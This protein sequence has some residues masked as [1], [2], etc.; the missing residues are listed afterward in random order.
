MTS[1]RP[2]GRTHTH[3][4]HWRT[5]AGT[6]QHAIKQGKKPLKRGPDRT[7]G[8]GTAPQRGQSSAGSDLLRRG[9]R[10]CRCPGE[11]W[12]GRM[13]EEWRHPRPANADGQ[14]QHDG[15]HGQCQREPMQTAQWTVARHA[16]HGGRRQGGRGLSIGAGQAG[17]GSHDGLHAHGGAKHQR[18]RLIHLT[19]NRRPQRQQCRPQQADTRHPDDEMPLQAPHGAGFYAGVAQ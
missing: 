5:S 11:E 8:S 9:A 18:R 6:R 7:C 15:H 14:H 4:A 10:L 2:V 12:P 16:I 19:Q 1:R 13:Q 3:A 17:C